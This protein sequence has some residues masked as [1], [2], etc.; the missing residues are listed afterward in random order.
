MQAVC[1]AVNP[2]VLQQLMSWPEAS[3][4]STSVRSPAW[5][6]AMKKAF[7]SKHTFLEF[8]EEL[9]VEEVEF[10]EVEDRFSDEL[11]SKSLL[12]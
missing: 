4:F 9:N 10:E 11:A 1:R 5:Q 6:A 8:L 3:R 2:S 7:L 12:D